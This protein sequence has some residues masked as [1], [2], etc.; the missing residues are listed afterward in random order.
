MERN[1][2]CAQYCIDVIRSVMQE[3]EVPAIPDGVT[4]QELFAYSKLHSVE[5]LVFNGLS[6]LEAD[7]TDPVWMYWANRAEM[8]LTQSIVQLADRDTV[9]AALTEAGMDVLPIKGS[10]LKEQYPQIDFRQMSDLDMLIHREDRER[11]KEIMFQ[12]GYEE[13]QVLSPHHDGYEKAPYTAVELHLQL[14]PDGDEHCDY[15]QNIWEKAKPVEGYNRLYRL[16]VEDEY[17][18]CM[19]HMKHHLEEMGC[20]IR[21]V[22]DSVVYR[23]LY[24]DMDR[25]YLAQEFH[26]LGIEDFVKQIE[27]MSDC[28]FGTGEALPENL[29][30]TASFILWS[31]TYGSLDTAVQNRLDALKEKYKNPLLVMT[32]YWGSRFFRPLDEM[33]GHYP[34]LKKLPVL[35]PVFWIVRIVKKVVTKPAAL[36][37]HFKEVCKEGAEND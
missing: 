36:L 31:G 35:L 34:I 13:E 33:K 30:K 5:A 24:P 8:I 26:K 12:L 17:I 18:F 2:I 23:N 15:Y 29:V 32:V 21:M 6:Q 7:E 4:L 10:W 19:L 14:L 22:L 27:T 1:R 28:W 9:F 37:R 25:V 16:P 11:A 20:G 3:K